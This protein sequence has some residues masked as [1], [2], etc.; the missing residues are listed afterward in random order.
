MFAPTELP[1]CLSKGY[2]SLPAALRGVFDAEALA[3]S[4][5]FVP[6]LLGGHIGS[7]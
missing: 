6:A 5:R 7:F 4:W 2:G 3:G 1:L